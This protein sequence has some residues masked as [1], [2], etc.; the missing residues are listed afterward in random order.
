MC[1]RIRNVE[2]CL[3]DFKIV[4]IVQIV[5]IVEVVSPVGWAAPTIGRSKLLPAPGGRACD[6]LR[7]AGPPACRKGRARPTL[8]SAA[9]RGR[10]YELRW[11]QPTLRAALLVGIAH[12]TG[13]LVGGHSPP[14]FCIL[15]AER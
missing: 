5:K 11:A 2:E 12:P 15:N 8:R 6:A 4:Q 9:E 3:Q 14:Y 7:R 10:P 1:K 13:C